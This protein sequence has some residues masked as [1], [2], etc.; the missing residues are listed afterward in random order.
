MQIRFFAFV[1]FV[2]LSFASPSQAA[3]RIGSLHSAV[4]AGL[5]LEEPEQNRMLTQLYIEK[6]IHFINANQLNSRQQLALFMNELASFRVLFHAVSCAADSAVKAL[7]IDYTEPVGAHANTAYHLAYKL[8]DYGGWWP[9]TNAAK[10]YHEDWK[11]LYNQALLYASNH[12]KDAHSKGKS[13]EHI[14]MV[15]YRTAEWIMLNYRLNHSESML[16][17]YTHALNLLPDD[18]YLAANP[19]GNSMDLAKFEDMKMRN[20]PKE[21]LDFLAFDAFLITCFSQALYPH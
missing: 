9:T 15:A 12:A 13:K 18:A 7:G 20:V 5:R 19:F 10:A 11:V 2:S 16:S 6:V 21:V 1:T 14:I 8:P 3:E 4:Q 17:R